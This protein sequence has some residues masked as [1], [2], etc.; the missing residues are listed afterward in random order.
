MANATT[1]E[2][3]LKKEQEFVPEFAGLKVRKDSNEHRA[4][5]QEFDPEKKYVYQ[6]AAENLEL[7]KPVI[8]ARTNR[9]LPHKPFK[10]FQNLIMTSQIVWNNGR[11]GIR[12]YDG[13][14]SIFV[15]EQ[16]KE[17]DVIDQ[18]IQQ[19]RR[20]NFLDGKLIVE[21]Y[22]K[23]LL[24]YLSICSWNS[25]SLFKTTTS[26]AI[27]TP[28]NSER[29][30][31]V[32]SEK[33]D[34]IE[35]AMKYAREASLTKMLIHS[36]FLGIPTTDYDSGNELTEKEIRIEYRKAAS[37]NP[38]SFIESYGN[39]QLEIKYYIDKALLNGTI[40]N[41]FNPN[42]A[43]W[44]KGN[45]VICDISGLKTNDAISQ[46]L[47]EFAKTAEGEEFVIQL[48]ALNES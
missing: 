48:K 17:K 25:E 20:R 41:K 23:M 45:T 2:A 16:P 29:L 38:Q 39:K 9:P 1:M 34:M 14:E 12:Y 35:E 42:K 8:D 3:P 5:I 21:G 32:E 33:L 26:T 13:C 15:S 30:A 11:V 31:T 4:L 19:T 43:T 40:S 6:L 7:D 44:G 24:L 28:Q 37:K 36:A 10:P 18:L 22:E 46:A 27:F 47:F